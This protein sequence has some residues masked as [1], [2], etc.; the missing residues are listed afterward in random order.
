MIAW[1]QNN[2]RD[3]LHQFLTAQQ[4]ELM[5][6]GVHIIPLS[7][8]Q[9]IYKRGHETYKGAINILNLNSKLQYLPFWTC[10]C[11]HLQKNQKEPM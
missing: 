5:Y 2:Q 10:S 9:K 8:L 11:L 1:L 7:V 6:Q 3:T 4:T